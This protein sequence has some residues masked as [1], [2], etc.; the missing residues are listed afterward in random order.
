MSERNDNWRYAPEHPNYR[1]Y[2]DGR[3]ENERTGR[4]LKA[5][6]NNS[7]Y[8]GL[9]LYKNGKRTH[10]DIHRLVAEIFVDGQKEGLEVNHKDG[11][12]LNNYPDNLEWITRGANETH[13][14]QNDLNRGPKHRPVRVVESGEVF[15]SIKACARGIR[16]YDANIKR[17]LDGKARTYL[18]LTFEYATDAE[19]NANSYLD[20]GSAK[21]VKRKPH[22][23][24]VRVI[25]TG[26][27]YNS[28]SECGT[29]VGGDTPGICGCLSGRHKTHR[30]YHYEYAD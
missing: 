21:Y 15:G 5:S 25:E 1:V 6:R 20:C 18:G 27:I 8:L 10:K 29:D 9:N 23:R 12:K 3:V 4:F 16:G 19:V 17:C 7:G 13:A 11:N 28:I 22:T 24:K 2:E 30:G 26:K 14:Y